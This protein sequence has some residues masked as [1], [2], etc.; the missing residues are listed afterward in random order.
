MMSPVESEVLAGRCMGFRT[1]E[2]HEE[3]TGPAAGRLRAW[4]RPSSRARWAQRVEEPLQR[5]Q[6]GWREREVGN[7]RKSSREPRKEVQ[8][9]TINVAEES[10]MISNEKQQWT[11]KPEGVWWR[12][13]RRRGR[14][15]TAWEESGWHRGS[16]EEEN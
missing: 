9:K 1:A 15:P 3:G 11:G 4:V 7:R 12:W 14:G 5:G 2:G 16:W 10:S 6:E 8:I 13:C